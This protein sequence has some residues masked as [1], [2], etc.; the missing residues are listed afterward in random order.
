MGLYKCGIKFHYYFK[1]GTVYAA[2]HYPIGVNFAFASMLQIID[3]FLF[4]C[5]LTENYI[6]I[7][8]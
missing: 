2:G 7:V 4:P 1:R 3:V 5:S 6:C 8:S